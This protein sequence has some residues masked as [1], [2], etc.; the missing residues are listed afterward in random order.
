MLKKV[1]V[2]F[3]LFMLA[4]GGTVYGEETC[5]D[6]RGTWEGIGEEVSHSHIN[7]PSFSSSSLV[8][9]ID[10]QNGCLFSGVIPG[11]FEVSIVGMLRKISAMQYAVTMQHPVA[12]FFGTRIIEGTFNCPSFIRK[13]FSS[14][15]QSGCNTMKTYYHSYYFNQ[16]VNAYFSNMGTLILTKQ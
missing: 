16:D 6:V 11:I 13:P 10:I 7:P 8:V 14:I 4:C 3:F 5:P 9:S 1:F 15:T 2:T 12:L